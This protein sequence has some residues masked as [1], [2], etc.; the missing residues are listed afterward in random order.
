MQQGFG[1]A[2]KEKAMLQKLIGAIDSL[3]RGF[4][5]LSVIF[6]G[7]CLS[8]L[9]AYVVLMLCIRIAEFFNRVLASHSW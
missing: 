7:A 5:C 9:G 2:S 8:A 6:M 1:Q 4:I 3:G